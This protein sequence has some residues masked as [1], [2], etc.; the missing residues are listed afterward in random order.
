MRAAARRQAAGSSSTRPVAS[1]SAAYSSGCVAGQPVDRVGR[2]FE[3]LARHQ[4]RVGVVVDDGRVLV[5]AG[6]G[7]DHEL[8]VAALGEEAEPEPE[9]RRLDQHLAAAVEHQRV[10]AGDRAVLADRVRDVRVDV[11]LRGAGGVARRRLLAGDRA[12]GEQRAAVVELAGASA[13]GVEHADPKREHVARLLRARV[14]E[15]R[16]DVDLG[17]PEVVALVAVAGDA[18]GRDAVAPGAG[19]RLQ[20]RE[21]VEADRALEPG[22]A[23]DLDVGV[24]PEVLGGVALVAL[25]RVVAGFR[26]ARERA[27]RRSAPP[28]SQ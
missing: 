27:L 15:E 8:A 28:P 14:R 26:G 3:V 19:G 7:V 23:L 25:D 16:R 18:L 6:H 12:P 13:G 5:R 4:V 24:A 22:L 21:E 9:A 1:T 20:E 10:V 11:V 2:C 17:V